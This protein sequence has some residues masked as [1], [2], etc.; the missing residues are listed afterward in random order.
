M[1]G[2]GLNI[3]CATKK[4]NRSFIFLKPLSPSIHILDQTGPNAFP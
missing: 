2:A 3:V 1:A 4:E